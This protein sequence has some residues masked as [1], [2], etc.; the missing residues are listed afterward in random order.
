MYISE[1]DFKLAETKSEKN[2]FRVKL[3]LLETKF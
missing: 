3:L 2:Y 1:T